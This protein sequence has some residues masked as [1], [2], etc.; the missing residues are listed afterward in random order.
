MTPEKKECRQ[1]KKKAPNTPC[2]GKRVAKFVP[3]KKKGGGAQKRGSPAEEMG[4]K[5]RVFF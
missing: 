3:G 4:K 5:R 2:K 1:E